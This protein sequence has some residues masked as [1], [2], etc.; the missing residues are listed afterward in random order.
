M[1]VAQVRQIPSVWHKVLWCLCCWFVGSFVCLHASTQM[2]AL[3]YVTCVQHQGSHQVEQGS[4]QVEQSSHQVEQSSHQ[5]EQSSHQVRG[6]GAWADRDPARW[7]Q[8]EESWIGERPR[9]NTCLSVGWVWCK[10]WVPQAGIG[11][12][13]VCFLCYQVVLLF[14]CTYRIGC[15]VITRSCIESQYPMQYL[16]RE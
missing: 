4:H 3:P 2:C 11:S 10:W 13:E 15:K 7:G 1:S 6:G 14:I 12:N 9:D 5:V 8:E 16:Y